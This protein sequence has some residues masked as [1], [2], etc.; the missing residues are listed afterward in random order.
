MKLTCFQIFMKY[1]F[2]SFFFFFGE[3][4]IVFVVTG[5]SKYIN[6]ELV[7]DEVNLKLVSLYPGLGTE[8]HW[9]PFHTE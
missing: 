3:L 6:S 4:S 9:E 2:L 5:V 1:F 7:E 8:N